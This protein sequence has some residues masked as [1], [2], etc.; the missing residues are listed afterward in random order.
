MFEELGK[1]EIWAQI[2]LSQTWIQ[3]KSTS[4]HW[5]TWRC[6]VGCLPGAPFKLDTY[7]SY[8]INQIGLP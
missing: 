2:L 5:T 3:L 7:I 8:V 1:I 4:Y 6:D